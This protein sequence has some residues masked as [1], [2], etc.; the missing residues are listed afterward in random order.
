MTGIFVNYRRDDAP[1][2]AGRLFDRLS[3]TFAQSEMF[4]DVDA[5]KPGLDFVKQLDEQVSKCNVMLAIIGP[6][7]LNARDEKGRRRLDLPRDSVRVELASALKREIPVI[8]LLVNGTAMPSEDDLPDDLKPL[9]NR[10]G[11]ELRH[12]RFAADSD[13]VIRALTEIMP[14]QRRYLRTAAVAAAVA[15]VCLLGAV[16]FLQGSGQRNTSTQS[17][18]PGNAA[19]PQLQI[20]PEKASPAVIPTPRPAPATTVAELP[21]TIIPAAPVASSPVI[22]EPPKIALIIGNSKYPD[23]EEPLK[24]AVSDARLIAD[25]LKRAGF[26][27]T[28]GENLT[29]GGMRQA[30]E[31]FYG[32]I[33]TNSVALLFFAGY[34][35]QSGRQTYLIPVDAQIWT[36]SDVA[37]DG[38]SL[39]ALL[40]QMNARGA[41]MKIALVD[42]SRRNPFERR[43]RS[44]SAGLTAVNIPAGTILMYSEAPGVVDNNV[45]S[46]GSGGGSNSV[47]ATEL[48]KNVGAPNLT[49]EDALNRSRIAISRSTNG[50]QVPWITSTLAETLTLGGASNISS[51]PPPMPASTPSTPR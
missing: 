5:M 4:M 6:G 50:R 9:A 2:V 36:E 49:A 42:A 40:R 28:V 10:H 14:A 20:R 7:W 16:F 32:R 46:D 27:V 22:G 51:P 25:G 1:G 19:N 13:A 37:R 45:A 47:F 43:F 39:E 33:D 35:V 8:P 17:A 26:Q 18:A 21:P 31:H 41:A 15:A 44:S 48:L 23:A 12:S 38:F 34:G 29:S 30:L 11:L 3:T 24:T